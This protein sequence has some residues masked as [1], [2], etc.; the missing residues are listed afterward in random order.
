MKPATI[1]FLAAASMFVVEG[2]SKSAPADP[3]GMQDL[4]VDISKA[5]QTASDRAKFVQAL[6][7]DQQVALRKKCSVIVS[8]PSSH[9]AQVVTFC[10]DLNNMA[11][12]AGAV[13]PASASGSIFATIPEDAILAYNLVGS[14]V[15]NTT[16]DDIGT[17]KDI[18][19]QR[20]RIDQLYVA[21]PLESHGYI[22]RES[23]E[24]T[25]CEMVEWFE[26][27]VK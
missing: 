12:A 22:A 6:P 10:N 4:G 9:A 1:I 25:L 21:L 11:T 20:D 7:P 3:S 2:P 8:Q 14:E 13:P 26:R 19:L 15:Y 27:Y 17:I 23:I 5:G 18:V 16:H 24:H